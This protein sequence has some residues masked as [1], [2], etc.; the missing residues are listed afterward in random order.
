MHWRPEQDAVYWIHLSTAQDAGLLRTRRQGCQRK[1]EKR[2]VRETAHTSTTTKSNI[3][4]IMGSHEI[5]YC[6]R[7]DLQGRAVHAKNRRTSPKT[8]DCKWNSRIRL[9]KG[10][11]SQCIGRE[12]LSEQAVQSTNKVQCRR[13]YSYFEVGFQVHFHWKYKQFFWGW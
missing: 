7:R 6:K 13:C 12:G 2:I 11:Y 9:T 3:Q 10:E 4:T 8:C 1:W 5:Q